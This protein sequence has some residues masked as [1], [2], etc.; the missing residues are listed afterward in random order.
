MSESTNTTTTTGSLEE[1]KARRSQRR[2]K[3]G[4]SSRAN[5]A[6]KSR[7]RAQNKNRARANAPDSD[8]A[9]IQ[10]GKGALKSRFGREQAL[11]RGSPGTN[12]AD[13]T[14][15]DDDA[16]S[17]SD[18]DVGD[19]QSLLDANGNP[20]GDPKRSRRQ[21]RK[22]LITPPVS[23]KFWQV[24]GDLGE[25]DGGQLSYPTVAARLNRAER[26]AKMEELSQKDSKGT[27]SGFSVDK[28]PAFAEG[29]ARSTKI[30][31]LK[32][33]LGQ[34]LST[35]QLPASASASRELKTQGKNVDQGEIKEQLESDWFLSS[36]H[37][38][39]LADPVNPQRVIPAPLMA[40]GGA[41]DVVK[42]EEFRT[43]HNQGHMGSSATTRG[44]S[45]RRSQVVIKFG[46]IRFSDHKD[47][48]QE[49][50][51]AHRLSN[52]HS[53]YWKIVSTDTE[54]H[55]LS[56]VLAC[57]A[58][59][60]A[61][62]DEVVQYSLLEQK[63]GA[64]LMDLAMD[65][66]Q[67]W[68]EYIGTFRTIRTL[69]K[70]VYAEWTKLKAHRE[71]EKISCTS[72]QLEVRKMALPISSD[73]GWNKISQTMRLLEE[74][75]E[76]LEPK[77]LEQAPNMAG[78][79]SSMR[80]RAVANFASFEAND[81]SLMAGKTSVPI[82]LLSEKHAITPE[83]GLDPKG[84]ID[85]IRRRARVGACQY[86]GRVVINGYPVSKTRIAGLR[87]PEFELDFGSTMRIEVVR[88]PEDVMFQIYKV[89]KLREGQIGDTL[90]STVPIALQGPTDTRTSSTT[91]A[92]VFAMY[93]F[94]ANKPDIPYQLDLQMPGGKNDDDD[95]DDDDENKDTN[96][97]FL[98]K[99]SRYT[100]GRVEITTTWLG[101]LT[102]RAEQDGADLWAPLPPERRQN[103]RAKLIGGPVDISGNLAVKNSTG[104]SKKT[105]RQHL[106]GV[107]L[108]NAVGNSRLDPNDPENTEIM[109][110]MRHR[111][112]TNVSVLR[113]SE[114]YRVE[115]MSGRSC[116][117]FKSR[118]S[119]KFRVPERQN[120]LQLRYARP[121]LFHNGK[122]LPLVD[123]EI[124]QDPHWRV[125]LAPKNRAKLLG[126]EPTEE[127]DEEEPDYFGFD[128]DYLIKRQNKMK[129]FVEKVRLAQLELRGTRRSRGM[130]ER[131]V[132]EG[133]MPDF[134]LDLSFIMDKFA[135][136]RKLKP[137]VKARK[138]AP[139][140]KDVYV[141][142]QVSSAF[143]VPMRRYTGT[144]KNDSAPASP[145][146]RGRRGQSPVRGAPQGTENDPNNAA[147]VVS[148]DDNSDDDEDLSGGPRACSSFVEGS[149]QG[150]HPRTSARGGTQPVW[151]ETL[152]MRFI[153]SYSGTTSRW[154]SSNM[155]QVRDRVRIS[156]FD[157]QVHQNEKDFRHR[158]SVN[159]RRERRYLGSV[160]V[161]FT[162]IYRRK[163][164]Q[165]LFRL[166]R[167]EINLAYETPI[168]PD[169]EP[170][171]AGSGGSERAL[172][173]ASAEA[174]C[175]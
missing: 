69:E 2:E 107:S 43:S 88:R 165:G 146:R 37:V 92:P 40:T 121:H 141:L 13:I 28:T 143:N 136:K 4:S 142:V 22:S 112:M 16:S 7:E 10:S 150:Q 153:P 42:P 20:T 49:D 116:A 75:L 29:N 36:G 25:K 95:D 18:S 27:G 128:S 30:G 147:A 15:D 94:S 5:V 68:S 170:E 89:G 149:F 31:R 70:Q 117:T 56:R 174:T 109:S 61:K 162:T 151:N 111:K 66:Y 144:G 118:D 106:E 81:M 157:E 102:D 91:T 154:T 137:K 38:K 160:S 163:S 78:A 132:R 167:P 124:M 82:F 155:K 60:G 152:R 41:V 138:E 100:S 48:K 71:N 51:I 26:R 168:S 173:M 156:L 115:S 104:K 12:A 57:G 119:T 52:L 11:A 110:L 130:L 64:E 159:E 120:L 90:V 131:W 140:I 164:I 14:S 74:T 105:S 99:V 58:V 129:S 59:L 158:N 54:S 80:D 34:E 103:D 6:R 134:Q 24:E 1:L 79:N 172:K 133:I 32:R 161:P 46:R 93:S 23:L 47:F 123:S 53:E 86:Y 77:L 108:L 98:P 3:G 45:G 97:F 73:K 62:R 84:N 122:P 113:G 35:D 125:M 55:H 72:L 139:L 127:D 83:G 50:I 166:D 171:G 126:G 101:W 145:T 65:M 76:L 135:P 8:S 63:Q 87:W 21:V 85:E 44:V 67:A 19:G 114:P 96:K 39:T 175:T 148:E 9:G 33:R 17:G 169:D